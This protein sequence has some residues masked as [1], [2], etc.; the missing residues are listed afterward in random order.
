MFVPALKKYDPMLFYGIMGRTQLNI[1][2]RPP[3][4]CTKLVV[5]RS[6]GGWLQRS[7][8]YNSTPLGFWATTVG[9]HIT[10]WPAQ[11]QSDISNQTEAECDSTASTAD[12]SGNFNGVWNFDRERSDSPD[13]QLLALQVPWW[14]RMVARRANPTMKIEH[15]TLDGDNL[16]GQPSSAIWN[17]HISLPGLGSFYEM[18]EELPLDGTPQH[19]TLHGFSIE[20]STSVDCGGK[21]VVTRTVVDQTHHGIIRRHLVDD[22]HTYHVESILRMSDGRVV[23]KNSYFNRA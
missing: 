14:K 13:E 6:V 7:M 17:E 1:F 4:K 20:K 21:E 15:P 3:R 9:Q 10:C 23:V 8:A 11:P 12:V 16:G 18:K 22:G 5:D 2:Q 19:S